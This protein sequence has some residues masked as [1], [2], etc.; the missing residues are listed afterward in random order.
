MELSEI[1]FGKFQKMMIEIG[2]M[3]KN[4]AFVLVFVTT[5]APS[6]GETE[7]RTLVQLYCIHGAPQERKEKGKVMVRMY[8][9]YPFCYTLLVSTTI[10]R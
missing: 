6:D 7:T 2:L 8:Y 1:F 9:I 4:D 10:S 5:K 3:K